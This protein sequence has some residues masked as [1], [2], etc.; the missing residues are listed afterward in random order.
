LIVTASS[1]IGSTFPACNCALSAVSI[2]LSVPI[3]AVSEILFTLAQDILIHIKMT[4]ISITNTI[5][6]FLYQ[7]V[8]TVLIA[9][10]RLFDCVFFIENIAT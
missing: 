7:K 2:S 3:F 4:A 6:R 9:T 8:L 1:G 10:S 5:V